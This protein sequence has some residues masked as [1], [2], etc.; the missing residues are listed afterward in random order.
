[1]PCWN[2]ST[3]KQRT[4]FSAR[5]ENGVFDDSAFLWL[6]GC[7]QC[8]S[9]IDS[10]LRSYGNFTCR[11]IG[12]TVVII[13]IPNVTFNALDVLATATV[14]LFHYRSPLLHDFTNAKECFFHAFSVSTPP[15]K[16]TQKGVLYGVT[17]CYC[18][19]APIIRR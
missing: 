14:F 11:T 13:A 1:M 16:Y 5:A 15:R 10:T 18:R 2:I 4:P 8:F 12:L 7:T 17:F 19:S 6:K 9:R 3:F